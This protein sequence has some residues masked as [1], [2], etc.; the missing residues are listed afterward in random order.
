[1]MRGSLS[2]GA[3]LSTCSTSS[4]RAGAAASPSRS[5]SKVSRQGSAALGAAVGPSP[6]TSRR[7]PPI[8]ASCIA[9]HPPRGT[10]CAERPGPSGSITAGTSH[11]GLSSAT[12]RAISAFLG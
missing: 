8:T 1:M 6:A 12:K 2:A 9:P 3:E 7:T 4:L 11:D 5:C 10:T